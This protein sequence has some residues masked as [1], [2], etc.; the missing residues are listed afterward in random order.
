[1]LA[2]AAATTTHTRTRFQPPVV[3]MVV[4]LGRVVALVVVAQPIFVEGLPS[5]MLR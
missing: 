2:A 4:A 3:A 5:Q 1:M